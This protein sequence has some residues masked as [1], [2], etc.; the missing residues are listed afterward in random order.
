M[1]PPLTPFGRLIPL[2]DRSSAGYLR[3]PYLIT[4][5]STAMDRFTQ[6]LVDLQKSFIERGA[7]SWVIDLRGNVGGNQWP[8]LA[9]LSGVLGDGMHGSMTLPNGRNQSWGTKPGAAWAQQPDQV[10]YGD[11]AF[12]APDTSTW[13]VA[14]LTDQRTASSAEAIAISF[15]GRPN[16]RSFGDATRGRSSANSMHS[17]SNGAVLALT[18]SVMMDRAGRSYGGPVVPDEVFSLPTPARDA[19]LPSET[20]SADPVLERA[21]NWLATPRVAAR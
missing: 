21:L 16:T 6:T 18:V 20:G 14:V 8:M 10:T 9:A 7:T 1:P 15:R 19:P 13:R 3:V 5:D 2:V 11:D 12:R 17:L 4:L